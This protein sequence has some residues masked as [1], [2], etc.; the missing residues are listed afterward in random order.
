[1][2]TKGTQ[3]QKVELTRFSSS[4]A[5]HQDN[6]AEQWPILI[7]LLKILLN[8]CVVQFCIIYTNCTFTEKDLPVI[9]RLL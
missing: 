4:L 1:V 2:E 7:F 6:N 3:E 8:L 9:L 5:V